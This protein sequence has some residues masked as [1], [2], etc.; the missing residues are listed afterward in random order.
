MAPGGYAHVNNTH[1]LRMSPAP[2]TR[3]LNEHA[4]NIKVFIQIDVPEEWPRAVITPAQ[5]FSPIHF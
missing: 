1:S 2:T 4:R 5:C 3:T